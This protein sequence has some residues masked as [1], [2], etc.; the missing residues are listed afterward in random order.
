MF[1]RQFLISELEVCF[2]AKT[3]YGKSISRPF[4]VFCVTEQVWIYKKWWYFLKNSMFKHSYRDEVEHFQSALM[5]GSRSSKFYQISSKLSFIRAKTMTRREFAGGFF[6][7][8][9]RGRTHTVAARRSTPPRFSPQAPLIPSHLT[10][11]E[12][13]AA[14]TQHNT[15]PR[16]R[17]PGAPCHHRAWGSS[18]NPFGYPPLSD[19][20]VSN[21][22]RIYL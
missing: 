6:S 11:A 12:G 10:M 16:W 15:P 7:A 4:F 13:D 18:V 14:E 20:N 8:R 2:T 17:R 5:K 9:A 19:I 1:S 3:N 22:P 21:I